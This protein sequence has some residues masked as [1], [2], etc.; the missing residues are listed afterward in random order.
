M[1]IGSTF[2]WFAASRS[3]DPNYVAVGSSSFKVQL[4]IS[5]K[6]FGKALIPLYDSSVADAYSN[7]CK[8]EMGNGLCLA[9]DI[10]VNNAGSPQTVVGTVTIT[11]EKLPHL[12]FLVYDEDGNIFQDVTAAPESGTYSL[13][14]DFTLNEITSKKLTIVFWVSGVDYDQTNEDAGGTFDAAITV[15]SISG[16]KLTGTLQGVTG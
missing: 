1:S 11:S 16:D 15:T 6:Y 9:Y 2:A 12:S 8:D 3:S 10:S 13:G 5:S 7:Q 14:P 4:G